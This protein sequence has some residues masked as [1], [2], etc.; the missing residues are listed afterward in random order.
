MEFLAPEFGLAASAAVAIGEVYQKVQDLSPPP[1]TLT[2]QVN[3]S[4]EKTDKQ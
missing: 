4:F 2:F 1:P 3:K